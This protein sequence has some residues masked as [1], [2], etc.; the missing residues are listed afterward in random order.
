MPEIVTGTNLLEVP[1]VDI[2]AWIAEH[3][4]DQPEI[5]SFITAY[6]QKLL[7]ENAGL[8]TITK[9]VVGE[10]IEVEETRLN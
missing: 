2:W 4:D 7:D 8:I 9:A 3:G 10:E 1:I 6:F 5:M